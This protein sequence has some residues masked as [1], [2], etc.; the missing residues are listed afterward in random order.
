MPEQWA[1]VPERIID[2]AGRL[3]HAQIENM[4]ALPLIE[5]YNDPRCLIYAD[6]PYMPETRRK[7]IYA[8][9]MDEAQHARLLDALIKHTGSVVL[10]GYE[11]A[12]YNER[13]HSWQRIEKKSAVER[14]QSRVEIL[15]IKRPQ[16][17]A[18][19]NKK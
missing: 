7:H 19:E 13:L 9:E 6:P 1:K 3:L 11:S 18:G 12:L 5:K 8:V 10:S 14:G 17:A 16:Y 4:D 15:W 2:T